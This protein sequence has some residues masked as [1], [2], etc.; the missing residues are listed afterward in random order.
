MG[1]PITEPFVIGGRSIAAGERARVELPVVNLYTSAPVML[2]VVLT[3]GRADGPTLFVSAALHGDE[4][5]GVEIIRRLLRMPALGELRGTLLAV[6]IVNTLAFLHQSR[7]L[8]DRRDLN[9][10]FPGSKSGSLAA[11]LAS[12]F[13][14]EIVDRSD[15]G[16]DLHTG[17]IHR[18]NLPQIRGDLGNPETLR[19]C[20]AFGIP[21]LLNS[22]PTEGTLREY[23]TKKGIPV[24]LYESAEALRFDEVCI[25]IGVQGVLNVLYELGMLERPKGTRL[26]AVEPVIAESSTW[27]RSPASGVLRAQ[28]ALGDVVQG[29][30]VIGIVGDP[31]SENETP[32]VS[33]ATGV[34]IGR[35]NLPLVHEGDATFHIARVNEPEIVA[36]EMERM[37]ERIS[38]RPGL[39][40]EAP[41]T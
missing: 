14:R 40:G 1:L 34:V 6:P 19:L 26:L 31:L 33:P 15:Y 12:L 10:S 17:A 39:A 22:E 21:L 24:I 32:I 18:P 27:A 3:R 16:I 37:R 35:L 11:R 38:A 20:K 8:P 29:G 30:Q 25:R 4:I 7:Y 23:T 2:P 28:A 5:I 36:E 13:L 9:R 41:I